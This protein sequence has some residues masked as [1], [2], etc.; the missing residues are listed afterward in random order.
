MGQDY[1]TDIRGVKFRVSDTGISTP[2]VQGP[3][4]C[5][6]AFDPVF[7][8]EVERACALG[9]YLIGNYRSRVR[10]T[11]KYIHYNP[12]DAR[13]YGV[14][15][16][17]GE[18]YGRYEVS[19]SGARHLFTDNW[20]TG[21]T[22]DIMRH[23]PHIGG[24]ITGTGIN[25]R[26][27]AFDLHSSSVFCDLYDITSINNAD[28]PHD[29]LSTGFQLRGYKNRVIGATTVG[30][31]VGGQVFANTGTQAD[32]LI[33]ENHTSYDK[34]YSLYITGLS[35]LSPKLS[36]IVRNCSYHPKS[37]RVI[38]VAEAVIRCEDV[39]VRPE[40]QSGG[41]VFDLAG[42]A[43]A[44]GNIKWVGDRAAGTWGLSIS[45]GS[46]T[47]AV[48]TKAEVA[49]AAPGDAAYTIT[50]LTPEVVVFSTTL[51][52]NRLISTSVTGRKRV[53][54][55]RTAG[56]AFNLSIVHTG[57]TL[58]LAQNQGVIVEI[59][60]ASVFLASPTIALA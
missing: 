48:T 13:A 20:Q 55:R 50:D 52:A 25:C 1:R 31:E 5:Q 22:G 4:W 46:N 2:W 51:T 34:K 16:T 41:A 11:I 45:N 27:A 36:A 9:M 47:I 54:I 43:D 10:A 18:S 23:G 14:W 30:N 28:G 15:V 38:R 49:D 37:N 42:N 7:D 53:M 33:V 6:G 57:G 56:G 17:S 21:N 19:G 3:L 59:H 8:V 40:G 12:S 35:S 24:R 44:Y 26:G 58:V 60:G 32:D 29:G 39:F